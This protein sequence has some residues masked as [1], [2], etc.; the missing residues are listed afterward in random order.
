MAKIPTEHRILF[1]LLSS[2]K[3][4]EPL[5]KITQDKGNTSAGIRSAIQVLDQYSNI[6]GGA[7]LKKKVK[8]ENPETYDYLLEMHGITRNPQ[9]Y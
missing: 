1:F 2:E 3:T 7:T 4:M 8:E 6:T 5:S 9:K